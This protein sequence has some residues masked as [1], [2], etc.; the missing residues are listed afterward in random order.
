MWIAPVLLSILVIGIA[1]GWPGDPERA[2]HYTHPA[3]A[4]GARASAAIAIIALIWAVY[5]VLLRAMP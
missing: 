5:F 1:S 3:R 2:M 4:A